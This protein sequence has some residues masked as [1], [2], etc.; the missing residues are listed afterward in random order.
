LRNEFIQIFFRAGKKKNGWYQKKYG[1]EFIHGKLLD[2]V[3]EW[4]IYFKG[5]S[6]D[7]ITNLHFCQFKLAGINQACSSV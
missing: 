5:Q 2:K 6:L 3:I 1:D 4:V 7:N